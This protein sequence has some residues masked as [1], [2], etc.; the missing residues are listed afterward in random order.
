MYLYHVYEFMLLNQ[1]YSRPIFYHVIKLM[2]IT[3]EVL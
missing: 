3:Q 1:K 2:V